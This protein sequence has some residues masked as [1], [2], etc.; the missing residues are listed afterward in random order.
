MGSVLLYDGLIALVIASIPLFLIDR[1]RKKKCGIL[2]AVLALV[3][4]TVF[5]GS[6]IEPKL[7]ATRRYETSIG[8]SDGNRVLS[9]AVISDLHLG[10]YRHGEWTK[11]V[12]DQVNALEPDLVI[13]A[14]DLVS[15]AAGMKAL[16]PLGGLQSRHGTYAVLGNWDYRIGAVDV[17]N[18]I[19]NYG[20]EVL[21]D[22]SV[23]VPAEG[24]DIRLI[25][26]DD[27]RYGMP[28][29]DKALADVPSDALSIVAVHNPDFVPAAE[30]RGID[31]VIAGHT[32]CGQI[33]LPL[34]GAVPNL[35][36]HIGR[37]FDCGV[38]DYGPTKLFI[39]PGAG[40]SGPRARLFDPPEVSLLRVMY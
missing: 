36:T 27:F 35:P 18:A 32:H 34:I 23:I 5:Y 10:V 37:R 7:L 38:F 39:T 6:F 13:L 16:S 31:L 4:A 40:E 30:V 15:N 25:G 24:T 22:E 9:I 12:V 3:W 1:T 33:R 8:S 17:R 19:E 28:D 20:V 11:R 26:L 2:C 14:G 29:W 21:T